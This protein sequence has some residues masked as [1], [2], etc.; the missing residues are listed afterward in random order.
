MASNS[1]FSLSS[2]EF[3]SNFSINEFSRYDIEN[4]FIIIVRDSNRALNRIDMHITENGCLV[5]ND[6]TYS[7]K[8]FQLVTVDD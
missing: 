4:K 7:P 8:D 1:V 5:L 2:D 6:K 3:K